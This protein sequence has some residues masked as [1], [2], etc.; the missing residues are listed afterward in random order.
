MELAAHWHRCQNLPQKRVTTPR[1]YREREDS[2]KDEGPSPLSMKQMPEC[3][4][5]VLLFDDVKHYT[6]SL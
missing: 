6:S 5:W 3:R 2:V 1:V 4:N